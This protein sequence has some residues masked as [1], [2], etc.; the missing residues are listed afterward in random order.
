MGLMRRMG[1]MGREYARGLT[2]IEH[3]FGAA[4]A[5]LGVLGVAADVVPVF[6]AAD[7]FLHAVIRFH[8]N[9]IGTF[10]LS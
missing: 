8:A 4:V 7:A 10:F 2:E 9:F 1:Q 3:D 5:E 6:P